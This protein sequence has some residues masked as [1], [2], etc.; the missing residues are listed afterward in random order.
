MSEDLYLGYDFVGKYESINIGKLPGRKS[1]CL[2][3]WVSNKPIENP[4]EEAIRNNW[5]QNYVLPL[6]YFR[7]E[8]SAR[9]AI[10]L[11]RQLSK[12]LY[13]KD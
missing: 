9:T 2:Y 3:H 10:Y 12:G 11:L 7:D 4:T 13:V 1:Y 5:T 8:E 6:A